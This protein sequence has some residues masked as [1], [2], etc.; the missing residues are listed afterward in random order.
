[1]VVE[2]Q[3][4]REGHVPT[5]S[6]V[7]QHWPVSY[8]MRRWRGHGPHEPHWFM[9]YSCTLQWVAEAACR[10]KYEV[11]REALEILASQLVHAFW[12]ETDVDLMMVSVKHCWEPAP[13]TRHHQK[14]NVPTTHVISYL[15]KMVVCIP[16]IEAWD[17]M[18]WPNTVAIL[19]VPTKAKSYGYCWGQSVDLG[20]VIPAGQFHVTE[21]RGTYLCT[22]TALVFE[23]SIH[24]YNPALNEAEWVPVHGMA[25]DLSWTEERSVVVL[26]N[27]ILH[28][29]T[30]VERITRLGVG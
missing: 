20:P 21:E 22:M 1:M 29:S 15:D 25:N 28:A 23:G 17:Q 30:E 3:G 18:V 10:R 12:H 9:A 19:C 14:E 13:R 6:L 8:L 5:C 7:P 27:Y 24:A 26:A 16:T 2:C 11:R 4:V